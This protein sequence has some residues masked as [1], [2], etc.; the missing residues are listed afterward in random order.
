MSSFSTSNKILGA[1]FKRSGVMYQGEQWVMTPGEIDDLTAIQ[2]TVAKEELAYENSQ[3]D[4]LEHN[5]FVD[6][7]PNV[8]IQEVKFG[9]RIEYNAVSAL[10]D[11]MIFIE[12]EIRLM[13]QKEDLIKT[14][15]YMRSMEWK[16]NG[17]SVT[18][19]GVPILDKGDQLVVHSTVNYAKYLEFGFNSKGRNPFK[20]KFI[21]RKVAAKA[22]IRFGRAFIFEHKLLQ[23]TEIPPKYVRGPVLRGRSK[24]RTVTKFTKDYYKRRW[25][26]SFPGIKITQRSN[27]KFFT[28]KA[29]RH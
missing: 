25:A 15:D 10:A 13:I 1:G 4:L 28:S 18:Q 3:G 17:K 6:N 14:G 12:H 23:T 27:V 5:V 9:G 16:R 8:P 29:T 7:R 24:G 21:F 19:T 20:G 11:V 22:R 2:V 26:V